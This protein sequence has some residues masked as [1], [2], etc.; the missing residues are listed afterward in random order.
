M[1]ICNLFPLRW[2]SRKQHVFRSRVEKS[3]CHSVTQ[4]A[5]YEAACT[6]FNSSENSWFHTYSTAH[7][8][9]RL[10]RSCSCLVAGGTIYAVNEATGFHWVN[11][12]HPS[13]PAGAWLFGLGPLR[14]FAQCRAQLGCSGLSSPFCD[15]PGLRGRRSFEGYVLR[16][17]SALV[18]HRFTAVAGLLKETGA[19]RPPLGSRKLWPVS[20][21]LPPRA[22]CSCRCFRRWCGCR[23]L[24]GRTGL[25]TSMRTGRPVAL[26]TTSKN[27]DDTTPRT[28]T[29][30]PLP[31]PSF[32][33]LDSSTDSQRGQPQWKPRRQLPW[34][35]WP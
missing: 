20:W 34:I 12:S 14:W 8:C 28:T 1:L 18:P 10:W 15:Y 13:S 6:Y 24:V 23:G 16:V 29:H 17:A 35:S 32:L 33:P 2:I 3:I 4:C 26:K 31:S 11:T 5:S 9:C 21:V 27:R 7:S 19:H 22:T 25:Q 30:L